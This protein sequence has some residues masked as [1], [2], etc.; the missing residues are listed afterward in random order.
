M[1]KIRRLIAKL[2]MHD[3]MEKRIL[4]HNLENVMDMLESME[5]RD[6]TMTHDV[7]FNL[8]T[9]CAKKDKKTTIAYTVTQGGMEWEIV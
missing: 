6:L 8:V 1:K 4:G 9:I 2:A 3:K 5:M 7:G